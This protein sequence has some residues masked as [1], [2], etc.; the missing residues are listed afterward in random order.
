MHWNFINPINGSMYNR[1]CTQVGPKTAASIAKACPQLTTLNAKY[2]SITPISIAPIL[3]SCT[4]LEVLKLGGIPNWVRHQFLSR[5]PLVLNMIQTD[6]TVT[7]LWK[8]LDLDNNPQFLL[9][10]L[11]SLDIRQMPISDSTI[12]RML[13]ICPNVER[14]NL[15]FTNVRRPPLLLGIK[16]L[17]KLS[18]TSTRI[19]PADLLAIVTDLPN[20]KSLSIGALGGGQGSS[21]AIDNPS[22]MTLTDTALRKLT[23]KLA[24]CKKLEHISLVG[25]T[26]LS[27]TA[28]RHFSA[29]EDFVQRVGRRC[30]VC[31]EHDFYWILDKLKGI[32]ETTLSPRD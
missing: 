25:N 22:A 29:L 31:V 27:G 16:T 13:S 21:V 4:A 20:L 9:S 18:V 24:L 17:K 12:N 2:T 7:K 11:R 10:N 30:T 5:T 6:A 15:S 8:A 26:K 23:D 28:G 19:D 3:R 1:G 14:L 32:L